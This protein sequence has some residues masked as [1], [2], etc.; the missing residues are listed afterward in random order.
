MRFLLFFCVAFAMLQTACKEEK[1]AKNN[2]E[3]HRDKVV[4]YKYQEVMY[5]AHNTFIWGVK[6]LDKPLLLELCYGGTYNTKYQ[7]TL[8]SPLM[9]EDIEFEAWTDALHTD[10]T[11]STGITNIYQMKKDGNEQAIVIFKTAYEWVGTYADSI[12]EMENRQKQI[13]CNGRVIDPYPTDRYFSHCP[14][15]IAIFERDLNNVWILNYFNKNIGQPGLSMFAPTDSVFQI[16]TEIVRGGYDDKTRSFRMDTTVIYEYGQRKVDSFRTRPIW[17]INFNEITAHSESDYSQNSIYIPIEKSIKK[18]I[19]LE[20]HTEFWND[21]YRKKGEL[22][23]YH[24]TKLTYTLV[25]AHR[26]YKYYDLKD[27]LAHRKGLDYDEKKKKSYKVD[28]KILYQFD[29]EKNEYVAK[30]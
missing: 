28:E 15:G 27:I 30:K 29:S 26:E 13:E 10:P 23:T 4:I 17:A 19:T 12:K 9:G 16:G 1:Q 14:T 2:F 6:S 18:M 7:A 5:N 8:W 24:D 11:V 21:I 3:K 22:E 25:D 20:E